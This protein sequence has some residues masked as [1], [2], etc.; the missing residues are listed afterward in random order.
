MTIQEAYKQLLLQLY[1]VYD[2]R[3]AA[4][5]ADLVIEHVTNQRR[6]DRIVNKQMPVSPAQLN[7][8][9]QHAQQLLKHKPIQYVLNEAWF[10]GMQLYVDENVLIPR[11]ETEELVSWITESQF[12]VS[13]LKFKVTGADDNR[14]PLTILD[15]GTGSGCMPIALKK[16][17]SGWDVH[18]IDISA[19]AL[20]VA[21]K[22]ALSQRTDVAFQ[23][24]DILDESSWQQLPMFD[25][26]VSNPPYILEKEAA[27]MHA[28]VLRFEPHTA[29]FVP[30]VDA[31][32]FYRN[33]ADFAL[34][35]LRENGLLFFEIN[36]SLGN[37]VCE[38]LAAKG[39]GDIELRRD[40]Q[41]KD[42]M[43]KVVLDRKKY[44][45]FLIPFTIL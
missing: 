32:L 45:P 2:D 9:E 34:L 30:D 36:E 17:F 15:I 1:E 18:A 3:E 13:S 4:N 11:P 43:V 5:I 41:G 35:H 42:R 40:L 29:L 26:I 44:N 21:K 8:I 27:T 6:I 20:E 19:S 16:K 38:M 14:I 28:N 12:E 10:A 23:L 7:Q 31:L 22:N 33:I 37:D 39:F 24:L 25:I